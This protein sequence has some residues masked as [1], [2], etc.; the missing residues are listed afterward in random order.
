MGALGKSEVAIDGHSVCEAVFAPPLHAE[1]ATDRYR[2]RAGLSPEPWLHRSLSAC[3]EHF[4]L[5][6]SQPLSLHQ[7]LTRSLRSQLPHPSFHVRTTVHCAYCKSHIRQQTDTSFCELNEE[8]STE[9][10]VCCTLHHDFTL[11]HCTSEGFLTLVINICRQFQFQSLQL[12]R[13]LGF[14]AK[15]IKY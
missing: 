15:Q 5:F 14:P 10:V 4:C 8:F 11:L 6:P 7:G 2:V 1:S 13:F 3:L 9:N 12:T